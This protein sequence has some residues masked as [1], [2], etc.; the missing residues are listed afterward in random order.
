[1]KREASMAIEIRGMVPL[2]QVFEMPT[3]IK[4]YR[5]VLGL[6]YNLRFSGRSIKR[7]RTAPDA[8]ANW[9]RQP[10]MAR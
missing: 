10:R 9:G 3:A 8:P 1:M 7:Q 5:D 2:F 4:F 6:G